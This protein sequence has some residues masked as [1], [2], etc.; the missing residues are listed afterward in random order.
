[1]VANPVVGDTF[2]PEDLLPVVDETVTVKAVGQK[3]TVPAGKFTGAIQV[4]E[5]SQLPDSRPETKWYVPGVGVAKGKTKGEA[6]ALV[7]STLTAQ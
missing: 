1:M 2:K 7:A 3:V 6:F 5:T 4:V